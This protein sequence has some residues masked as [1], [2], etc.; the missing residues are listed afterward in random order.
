MPGSI[1]K[2]EI[3]KIVLE[4]WGRETNECVIY[5]NAPRQDGSNCGM[6]ALQNLEFLAANFDW[7]DDLSKDNLSNLVGFMKKRGPEN[8]RNAYIYKG[9]NIKYLRLALFGV[10]LRV[11]DMKPQYSNAL[12]G[13]LREQ[14][15]NFLLTNFLSMECTKKHQWAREDP[16]VKI[17][18]LISENKTL[19]ILSHE[20]KFPSMD[21]PKELKKMLRSS[22]V[23]ETEKIAVSLKSTIS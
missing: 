2:R 23:M 13:V 7:F 17:K 21:I 1:D 18:S 19:L 3:E 14:N 10:M 9:P 22:V 11:V 16:L 4:E 20:N 15:P 12:L 6:H 5:V 8:N